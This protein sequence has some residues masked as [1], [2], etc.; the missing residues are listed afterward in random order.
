MEL[1]SAS[2][3]SPGVAPGMFFV[4][5]KLVGCNIFVAHDP[6]L[7]KFWVLRIS[8]K[9]PQRPPDLAKG[10]KITAQPKVNSRPVPSVVKVRYKLMLYF[11]A[12]RG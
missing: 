7:H 5:P 6:G 11:Q 3:Y 10:K 2:V 9:N 12:G 4:T 1:P 8:G